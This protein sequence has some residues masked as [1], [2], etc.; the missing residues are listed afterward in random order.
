MRRDSSSSIVE[1]GYDGLV[2]PMLEGIG[3]V[4]DARRADGDFYSFETTEPSFSPVTED[5]MLYRYYCDESLA[6]KTA[7]CSGLL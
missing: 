2:L 6:D 3:G 4:S 5:P 1:Q 7:C